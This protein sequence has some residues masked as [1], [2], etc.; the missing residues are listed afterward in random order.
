MTIKEKP[1]SKAKAERRRQEWLTFYLIFEVLDQQVKE[2]E[3][4]GQWRKAR[5][6]VEQAKRRFQEMARGKWRTRYLEELEK[7]HS[8]FFL[9]EIIPQEVK[10]AVAREIQEEREYQVEGIL[11]Y[12]ATLGRGDGEGPNG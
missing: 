12:A 5:E 10:D 3:W 6:I 9:G 2:R 4:S 1:I 7:R 11:S 8:L